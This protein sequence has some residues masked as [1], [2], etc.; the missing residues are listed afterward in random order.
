MER[1]LTD[2]GFSTRD[3][4]FDPALGAPNLQRVASM[5]DNQVNTQP[6]RDTDA[7]V[8]M[9]DVDDVSAVAK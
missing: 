4:L 7:T 1:I 2:A 6:H 8:H 5:T 9:D 3:I